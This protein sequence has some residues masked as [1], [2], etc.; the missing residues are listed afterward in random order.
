[1][2]I[3]ALSIRRALAERLPDDVELGEQRKDPN[4]NAGH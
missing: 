4:Q 2:A 1:M 3:R